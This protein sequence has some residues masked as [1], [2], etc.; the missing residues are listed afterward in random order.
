[1][2]K[3]IEKKLHIPRIRITKRSEDDLPYWK[4]W[5]IRGIA[6]LSS[7]IVCGLITVLLVKINPLDVYAKMFKGAFGT[8]RRLLV[9]LKEL[10]LLLCVAL[11]VTPAFKMRFW[12]IGAEGQILAGGLA[13]AA[14]MLY[15][16][17]L[18]LPL[19]LIVTLLVGMIAGAVWG[20]IPAIFKAWFGTNETLFTLMMNYVAMQLISYFLK[21]WDK[22]GSN[23][24]NQ[25]LLDPGGKI[26]NNFFGDGF[27][28]T[29]AVAAL[30]TGLM[31]CY[32]RYSKQGYEISVVGESEN[33]ARYV[34]IDVKKVIIRT[35]AI[36]GA[37][38]GLCGFLMVGATSQSISPDTAGGRGFTA[39]MVS[40][41]AKFNPIVMVLTSFLLVFMERGASEISSAFYLN[42]A[43]GEIL[44]G[45]I[46][47]FII[48]S[49][50]F[51]NYQVHLRKTEKEEA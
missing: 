12:N 15:F 36:S 2:S 23:V 17:P 27:V 46:L 42:D 48:G 13:T 51:V 14:C 49:E 9:T 26:W 16:R 1:M 21:I 35:M 24:V 37:I 6:V 20:V 47:F 50:F 10:S 7:L 33:T 18:P 8:Q 31:Y 11:A 25:K 22:S 40:W 30:L 44:T 34:G 39:I 38:C 45:V 5:M 43:F 3:T 19:L 41:L 29:I 4:A 32:L 28:V